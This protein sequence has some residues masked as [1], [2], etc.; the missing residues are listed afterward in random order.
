MIQQSVRNGSLTYGSPT[1]LAFRKAVEVSS[2]IDLFITNMD[3]SS[4][5]ASLLD[6]ECDLS[7]GSD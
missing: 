5:S 1:F 3:P 2:T 4:L 6:V 7:L